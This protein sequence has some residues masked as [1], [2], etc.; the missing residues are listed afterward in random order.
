MC[1]IND[2]AAANAI[3]PVGE[4][5]PTTSCFTCSRLNASTFLIV[6][7]DKYRECPF[8]YVKVFASVL[9]LIDTGCGGAAQDPS[10]ELTSLRRHLEKFPLPE[11]GDQPLNPQ[12]Q[13][14]YAVIC[15]HC[16]FD[17]IGKICLIQD[18]EPRLT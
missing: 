7:E 14:G 3:S 6:E 13:K 4:K 8:I 1:V 5:G 2:R 17:H 9:V 11:N 10:V 18:R 15:T 12:S 16:H